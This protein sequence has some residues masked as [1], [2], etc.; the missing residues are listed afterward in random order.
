M[1]WVEDVRTNLWAFPRGMKRDGAAGLKS[2]AWTS[3]YGSIVAS[4]YD[5]ATADGMN[6]TGLVTNSLELAESDYGKPDGT[7]PTISIFAWAQYVLDNFAAVAEAVDALRREPFIVIAP[8]VPIGVKAHGHLSLSDPTGDSAIFEYVGGKLIIHHGREY[9]V[10]TNS[11]VYDEQLALYKSWEKI[12]GKTMLP[13]TDW[14]ANRFVRA[15][16]CIKAIPQTDDTNQAVASVF[17]VIRSLSVPLGMTTPGQLNIA[18]TYWR[19]VADHKNKV[20]YFESATNLKVLWVPLGELDFQEGAPVKELTLVGGR[21]YSGNAAAEFKEAKPFE[22]LPAKADW[23]PS[24]RS[25][26]RP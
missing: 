12:G 21:A 14:S 22:F 2:I 8:K 7:K 9:Q 15:S 11:P 26:G 18:S 13:G 25:N 20:Y 6:E 1:D 5:V 19:T 3:K 4:A 17:G 10:M 23:G 24:S 16:F